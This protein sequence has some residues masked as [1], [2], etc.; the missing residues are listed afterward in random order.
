MTA[1]ESSGVST[2][3]VHVATPEGEVVEKAVEYTY[4]H[5]DEEPEPSCEMFRA[6]GFV[7]Y[8]DRPLHKNVY[9]IPSELLDAFVENWGMHGERL[10]EVEQ[11]TKERARRELGE[12]QED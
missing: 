9:Y 5:V 4:E 10:V 12:H 1:E 11:I 6:V 3:S 2:T 8:V 7:E